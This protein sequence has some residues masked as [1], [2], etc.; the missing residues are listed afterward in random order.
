LGR[1]FLLQ[2]GDPGASGGEARGGV[3]TAEPRPPEGD[4][5]TLLRNAPTADLF[6]RNAKGTA[7]RSKPSWYIVASDD[8]T[9]HPKLRRFV[10][11]RT[12]AT[13]YEVRSNHVSM[14]SQPTPAS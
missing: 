7:S 5:A 14:L 10:A 9:V 8:R 12:G 6:S 2:H 1:Q 13:T 4:V 11:N 3:L